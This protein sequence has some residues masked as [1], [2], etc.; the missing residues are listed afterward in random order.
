MCSKMLQIEQ[1]LIPFLF[2]KFR[3]G[4][5]SWRCLG[6][7]SL[8]F[9]VVQFLFVSLGRFPPLW[10]EFLTCRYDEKRKSKREKFKGK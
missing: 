2:S 6:N 8:T 1:F 9:L 4:L 5:S 10:H 7:T 3:E